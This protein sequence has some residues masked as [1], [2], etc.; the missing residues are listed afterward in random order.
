MSLNSLLRVAR[1]VVTDTHLEPYLVSLVD[2]INKLL[3]WRIPGEADGS[4]V[5]S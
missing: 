4:R 5:D 1:N 2:A 3:R